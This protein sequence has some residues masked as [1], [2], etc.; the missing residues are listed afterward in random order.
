MVHQYSLWYVY[1]RKPA[2]YA[3]HTIPFCKFVV[4]FCFL[5]FFKTFSQ[6]PPIF[7]I[8]LCAP[9]IRVYIGIFYS[10]NSW[11]RFF[12]FCEGGNM[13]IHLRNFLQ[14]NTLVFWPPQPNKDIHSYLSHLCIIIYISVHP[15]SQLIEPHYLTIITPPTPNRTIFIIIIKPQHK[16]G[17]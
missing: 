15:L 10:Q 11:L 16:Y 8:Q 13:L 4:V 3:H 17:R 6:N 12:T 7:L 5:W 9:F 14:N 1:Y 2:A